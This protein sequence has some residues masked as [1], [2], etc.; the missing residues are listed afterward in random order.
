[1]LPKEKEAGQ[2]T[3]EHKNERKGK[4]M[5][6]E[7]NNNNNNEQKEGKNMEKKITLVELKTAMENANMARENTDSILAASYL[8]T[9][10]D[11][12]G[13]FADYN[14]E[15]LSAAYEEMTTPADVMRRAHYS[16]LHSQWDKK[17]NTF[18]AVSRKTR[19][20]VLDFIEKKGIKSALPETIKALADKLTAFV[21]SEVQFDGKGKKAMNV[22]EVGPM[23]SAVIEEIGIDGI[24]S[25]VRDVRFLAYSCTGGAAT[26]GTLRDITPA[27]V[28][29]ALIDVYHVQ[30]TGGA[31]AFESEVKKAEK[32]AK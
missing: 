8:D 31:Y 23:L 6:N 21:Q 12:D 5:K 10:D 28:A 15:L 27:K 24:Y 22:R 14:K 17:A 18:K 30:L 11:M 13:T 32:A 26:I 29:L 16:P 3:Q 25:R 2:K 9:M 19:L 1:M 4:T 20:N 7:H